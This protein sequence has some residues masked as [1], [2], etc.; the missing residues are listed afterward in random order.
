[1]WTW[2]WTLTSVASSGRRDADGGLRAGDA[3]GGLRLPRRVASS[4]SAVAA[5]SPARSGLCFHGNGGSAL[6]L[7]VDVAGGSLCI[8]RSGGLRVHV[9]CSGLGL[10]LG[11]GSLG[12]HIHIF[13]HS[14]SCLGLHVARNDGDLTPHVR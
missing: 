7:R 4:V 6:R 13:R 5:S 1:M 14:R 2:V 3:G 9:G 10:H 11:C 12:D 8:Q